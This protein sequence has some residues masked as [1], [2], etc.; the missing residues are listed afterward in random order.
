MENNQEN[1]IIDSSN[2]ES[3]S[4]KR[5]MHD[6]FT[7]L[8][9][10]LVEL[11][12]LNFAFIL[13][14][15][16]II[17]IPAALAAMSCL[18]YRMLSHQPFHLWQDLIRLFKREFLRSLP[19]GALYATTFGI[20]IYLLILALPSPAHGSTAAD[21]LVSGGIILLLAFA[22]QAAAYS[23]A[24]IGIVNLSVTNVIRNSFRL[25]FYRIGANIGSA[26]FALILT[27]AMFL[28]FPFTL[29]L[30]FVFFFSPIC[31][32]SIYLLKPGIDRCIL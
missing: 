17:T 19:I 21:Y 16:P 4:N 18:C 15:I 3:P 2:N 24:L 14:C 22:F 6:F 32:V 9:E 23:F 27:L 26:L 10:N 29:P 25:T 11:V 1:D 31:F 12:K 7:V 30:L 8:C 13:I 20:L 5:G 28:T